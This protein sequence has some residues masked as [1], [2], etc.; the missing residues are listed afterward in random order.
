MAL[1]DAL[2]RSVD[3]PLRIFPDVFVP[4]VE[5][6]DA[7]KRWAKSSPRD[8]TSWE[9]FRTALLAGTTPVPP[10]M[11]T[12]LGKALV[13]AGETQMSFSRFVGVVTPPPPPSP[14]VVWDGPLVITA[15]GTYSGN[16][17]S[18]SP[19]TPAIR[20]NT[21]AA[22]T[23]TGRVRNLAG[24]ALID[25]VGSGPVQITLDHLFAYGGDTYQT[26]GRFLDAE[27][28]Q[29]ITVRSCTIEN[30]RGID[31]ALGVAGCTVLITKNRHRNIKGAPAAPPQGNFAQ[32]RAFIPAS[33]EISWNEILN[34]YD[35]SEP[36]D[37]ISLYYVSSCQ[38]HD[39]F[40]LHQSRVG[41]LSGSSQ[42]GI[43]IDG[44][45]TPGSPFKPSNNHVYA[46]QVID[47][48]GIVTY[49]TQGGDNNL[50]E[51]NRIVA[52]RLL[53]NGA[54]KAN[55]SGSPLAITPG[56]TGNHAHGNVVGYVDKDGTYIS[57]SVLANSLTGAPEGG[58]TEAGNNT[59]LPLNQ[60]TAQAEL[61]E[62]TLWEQ[63]LAANGI[64]IGA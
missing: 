60:I 13:A 29:A 63:K 25:A 6:S 35:K 23:I 10:A 21:T 28:F 50:V 52:D 31:L 19:A 41:N 40:L 38:V 7:Y 3:D 22:V 44:S 17:E 49:V 36:E 2:G 37:I 16:W 18:I 9:T 14:P 59:V 42:S 47:G 46:N 33:V 4:N 51:N 30:T 43:M 45:D 64:T 55:G 8:R 57:A 1:A 12:R 56:G 24:G 32:L 27:G 5:A 20:V 53:P 48:Y 15:G 34:E 54:D 58:A 62:R 26:S 39:N 11:A 61:N